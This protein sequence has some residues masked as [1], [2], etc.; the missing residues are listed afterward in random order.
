MC[1]HLGSSFPQFWRLF[2]EFFF[3]FWRMF[4][5]CH[6]TSCCLQSQVSQFYLRQAVL[7]D[8]KRDLS[9]STERVEKEEILFFLPLWSIPSSPVWLKSHYLEL[10]KLGNLCKE[11]YQVT[12]WQ[13]LGCL[14][15]KGE[16]SLIPLISAVL[17]KVS[18][19]SFPPRWLYNGR[20]LPGF[21]TS[22]LES[23]FCSV[24]LLFLLGGKHSIDA[25][26]HF[27]NYIFVLIH[28]VPLNVL[29]SGSTS[30]FLF[31]ME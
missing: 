23:Y 17:I 24:S 29:Q 22:R 13:R 9:T 12:K 30:L 11:L 1:R 31:Q 26:L 14:L 10:L 18:L 4:W 2:W 25:S 3:L 19:L 28:F 27:S 8:I 7:D 21:S 20:L 16:S 6:V 5:E 15:V